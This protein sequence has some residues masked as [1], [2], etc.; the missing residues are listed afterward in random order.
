MSRFS[1]KQHAGA[2]REHR[3]KLRQ[4]AEAR[5]SHPKE[6]QG[7]CNKSGTDK[8]GKG[9]AKVSENFKPKKTR[10]GKR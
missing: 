5:N 4:E 6:P 2:M 9:A 3:A 1:G 10:R 8:S 7:S